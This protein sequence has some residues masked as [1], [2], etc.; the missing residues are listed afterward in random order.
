MNNKTSV[1]LNC[2]CFKNRS[3]ISVRVQSDEALKIQKSTLCVAGPRYESC[4]V[5]PREDSVCVC[6]RGVLI[7]MNY[8]R[9]L[10]NKNRKGHGRNKYV[11]KLVQR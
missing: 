6:G 11:H 4:E 1:K 2:R 3:M 9:Y 8:S 10:E 7:F 5:L